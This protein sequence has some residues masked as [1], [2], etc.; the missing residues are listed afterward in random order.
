MN[1]SE[2]FNLHESINTFSLLWIILGIATFVILFYGKVTAPFGRHTRSDWGPVI[3]NSLGW[4]I[5]EIISP[6]GLW[7]GFYFGSDGT[8]ETS[9]QAFIGML[10]WSIHYLNRTFIFPLRMPNKK[11]KMP[12]II[13]LSAMLFNSVNGTLNGYFLGSD[14]ILHSNYLLLLGG[15]LFVLGMSINIKSDNILLSLRKPGET[16]YVIPRGFLFDKVSTPNLFG[17]I[18]EWFGF[19]LIVPSFGSLSF[20]CWTLANLIPRARDHHEW[21]LS[22]FDD[23]PKERKVV[24]PLIY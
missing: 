1:F 11:K 18:V 4:F 17:E 24:F 21:Y 20:L 15:L 3:P 19:M 7:V 6:I 12:L 8:M 14:W 5:M 10:L 23:Y 2:N 16:H 13:T 22:H 9:N